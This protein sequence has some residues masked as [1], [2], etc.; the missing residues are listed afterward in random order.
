MLITLLLILKNLKIIKFFFD[1]FYEKLSFRVERIEGYFF[2]IS[3]PDKLSLQSI[4][5]SY[6]NIRFE[7]H[8]KYFKSLD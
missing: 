8:D 5:K 2:R 4:L 6:P 7:K 3:D 1:S